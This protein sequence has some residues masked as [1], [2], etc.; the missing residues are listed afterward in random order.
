MLN[1]LAKYIN[2]PTIVIS[3]G[4]II[5]FLYLFSF[6]FPITDN[7][8]VVANSTPVSATVS[9]YVTQIHVANGQFVKKNE[10]IL[11]VFQEPYQ[12]MLNKAKANHEE[13]IQKL[14]IL[15]KECEKTEQLLRAANQLF[16]RLKYEHGLKNQPSVENAVSKMDVT[17]LNYDTQE[18]QN[19]VSALSKQAE[20]DIRAIKQQEQKIL[21]LK[22]ELD[23]AQINL[24]QT[25]VRA[26][27]D[28]YI[29]NL[30]IG[31]RAPIKPQ[32]PLFSLVDTNET[33]IQANFNET[34]LRDVKIGDEVIIVPRMYFGSKTYHGRVM[35]DY[36]AAERQV[37]NSRSQIQ[38][39]KNENQWL[40]LPQR[41]P[42]QI[43]II[44]LDPKYPMRTGMSAYVYIRT[45]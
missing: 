22:A 38:F 7:A 44:D 5:A 30:F 31:L 14:H 34:D 19:R 1:K 6:L 3:T 29:Q 17:K 23:E 24:E 2:F 28:G 42:V 27:S 9:G 41:M 18:Q 13:A 16:E 12:L 21:S 15:E 26:L 10:P 4:T 40:L 37:T 36:W 20:I 8:F 39:V 45:K 32:E 11:T 43:K 25:V 33:F 35:S